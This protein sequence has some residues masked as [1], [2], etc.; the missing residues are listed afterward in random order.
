MASPIFENRENWSI[1]FETMWLRTF[2][3]TGKVDW[4]LYQRP[5]NETRITGK[6]IDLSQSRLMLI[7]SA[8]G[9]LKDSQEPYDA[10]NIL[11]DY[12]IRTYPAETPLDALAYSHDHYDHT[13]V[14]E[15]AQVLIPLRHLDDMVAEGKIGELAPALSFM[16]Y[17]PDV[18]RV[19]DEMIPEIVAFAK[20][21][22]IQ[23]ALLV[24]S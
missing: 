4:S 22:N 6:G 10:E 16:G 14:N 3:E 20:E 15:D 2:K 19:E 17:Q 8:G 12:T 18:R 9:Y 11:G 21:Q 5:R 7:T 13:A 24:P 23:A 1:N